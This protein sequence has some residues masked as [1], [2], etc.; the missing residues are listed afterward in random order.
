MAKDPRK[1]KED[2]K[3]EAAAMAAFG[4]HLD[5]IAEALDVLYIPNNASGRL[6]FRDKWDFLA[7]YILGEEL[8]DYDINGVKD[9]DRRKVLE[10]EANGRRLKLKATLQEMVVKSVDS[11][12]LQ[13]DYVG[14][15]IDEYGPKLS[16]ML[17]AENVIERVRPGILKTMR[18]AEK[19]AKKK[20][21]EQ[22]PDKD[23][24]DVADDQTLSNDEATLLQSKEP[25]ERFDESD[26]SDVK[27]IVTEAPKGKVRDALEEMVSDF[28]SDSLK[29]STD[30]ESASKAK[31][32]L[33]DLS[34]VESNQPDQ[35]GDTIKPGDGVIE[36][37]KTDLVDIIETVEKQDDL[38]DVSD[39]EKTLAEADIEKA[40]NAASEQ[41][42]AVD[43]ASELAP[44]IHEENKESES[45]VVDGDVAIDDKAN[46][47]EDDGEVRNTVLAENVD[48]QEDR[49]PTL[50]DG[51]VDDRGIF[52]GRGLDNGGDDDT[53]TLSDDFWTD[54]DPE[55]IAV[56]KS[57]TFEENLTPPL[58]DVEKG[59]DI[60]AKPEAPESPPAPVFD[61]MVVSAGVPV[62]MQDA[63][64]DKTPPELASGA[65]ISD[66]DEKATELK[67]S[68]GGAV[69]P[70]IF[71][72]PT[73]SEQPKKEA[74]KDQFNRLAS[75]MPD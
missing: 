13:F 45:V 72:A 47:G 30:G 50:D 1:E 59:S 2:A 28:K 29:T 31:D 52:T 40:Q 66:E 38:S 42:Q 18:D 69:K 4:S 70:A 35:A 8:M 51:S 20:S 49:K 53:E 74:Y 16:E 41:D 11:G 68:E 44:L 3:R 27:P 58:E 57:S 54:G 23:S 32:D 62:E 14:R 9:H 19:E 5:D 24:K 25:E 12:Q 7:G 55:P 60:E 15:V 10:E 67:E 65:P 46:V 39:V 71:G 73:L 75:V 37:P 33:D 63:G 36:D 64:L 43:S 26:Y 48:D 6:K 21:A 22:K 34:D 56:P 17:Y 61:D